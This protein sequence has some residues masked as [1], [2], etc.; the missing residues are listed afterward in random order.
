M[1]KTQRSKFD[2]RSCEVLSLHNLLADGSQYR[3]FCEQLC[4]I[5]L[6]NGLVV[7]KKEVGVLTF[8]AHKVTSKEQNS[9]AE[10]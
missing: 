2:C 10:T 3:C 8:Q 9:P 4:A 1:K 6:E 5:C 7:D